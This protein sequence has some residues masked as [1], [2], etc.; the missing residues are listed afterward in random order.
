MDNKKYYLTING[1]KVSVSEEVYHAY[2]QGYRKE[3]YMAKDLKTG[4]IAT[5]ADSIV[6]I[7]SR[8]D[9]YE[10]LLELDRQFPDTR[11]PQPEVAI[12]KAEMLQTDRKSTRLNSS[13]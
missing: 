8:E 7:P 1:Q 4:R 3:R 5:T 10:R 6:E 2:N 11:E 13:H 12:C 9:S